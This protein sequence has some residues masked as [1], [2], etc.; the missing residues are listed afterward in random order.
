MKYLR[1]SLPL[2]LLFSVQTHTEADFTVAEKARIAQMAAGKIAT[3]LADEAQED[4]HIA[5]EKTKEL[6]H[7]IE[8]GAQHAKEAITSAVGQSAVQVALEKAD[9]QTAKAEEYKARAEQL[10]DQEKRMEKEVARLHEQIRL[11]QIEITATQQALNRLAT[12]AG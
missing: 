11:I 12:T 7:S 3:S 1:L 6:A 9:A 4:A 8:Q 2:F 10:Q 5:V